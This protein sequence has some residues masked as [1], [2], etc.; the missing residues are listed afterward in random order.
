MPKQ[1]FVT[2]VREPEVEEVEVTL[3]VRSYGVVLKVKHYYIC[4]LKNT[5]ELL[6]HSG[7]GGCG[8]KTDSG[9]TV[10]VTRED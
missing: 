1:K 8:V 7:V 9:G 5:G 10:I 6:L 3:E 2:K 4:T